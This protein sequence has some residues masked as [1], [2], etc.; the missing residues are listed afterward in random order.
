MPTII[1]EDG[2]KVADANSYVDVTDADTFFDAHPTAAEDWAGLV[3]DDKTRLLLG[4]A[5]AIDSCMQWL[6]FKSF[7][8]QPM[9]WPRILARDKSQYGGAYFVST[10]SYLAQYFDPTKVPQAVKDAQCEM[11]RFMM[12]ALL[13]E[14][15]ACKD[16]V[17]QAVGTTQSRL[18]D[19]PGKGVA[20]FEVVGGIKVAYD[21]ADQ[22]QII[23]DFVAM[24]LAEVGSPRS[25]S[26]G[27]SAAYRA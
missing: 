12:G 17:G 23:P 14:D 7:I 20:D 19:A 16:K 15:A 4:S 11:A 9:Q 27:N 13:A 21:K 6:G 2:S 18:D 5:R 3:V 1:K 26:S 24:I 8:N 10:Q 25:R 22:R